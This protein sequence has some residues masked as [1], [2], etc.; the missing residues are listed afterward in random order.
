MLA[1]CSKITG[2]STF[3][4]AAFTKFHINFFKIDRSDNR[5]ENLYVYLAVC[6]NTLKNKEYIYPINEKACKEENIKKS[7]KKSCVCFLLAWCFTSFLSRNVD[8]F[9]FSRVFS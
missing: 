6:I 4:G 5:L 7:L 3:I 9:A 8:N 1:P 2:F